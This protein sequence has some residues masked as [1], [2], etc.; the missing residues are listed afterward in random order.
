[1][2][3]SNWRTDLGVNV[4]YSLV[5]KRQT[6]NK[7]VIRSFLSK[8]G[9]HEQWIELII[10]KD[11]IKAIF[12]VIMCVRVP[13]IALLHTCCPNIIINCSSLSHSNVSP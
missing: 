3:I 13:K 8:Y 5:K 4:L 10:W 1:M 7:L 6:K 9:T 11:L 12:R 2:F